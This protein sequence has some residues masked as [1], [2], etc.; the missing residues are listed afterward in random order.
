MAMIEV[1]L[2][3]VFAV[4]FQKPHQN[5]NHVVRHQKHHLQSH[6]QHFNLMFCSFTLQP[7][8][9]LLSRNQQGQVYVS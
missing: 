3:R 6:A 5:L 7:L 1:L 4:D 2:K 9:S 8:Q